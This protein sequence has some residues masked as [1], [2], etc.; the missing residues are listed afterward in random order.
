MMTKEA[1]LKGLNMYHKRL[2]N[3]F[4]DAGNVVVGKKSSTV[5]GTMWFTIDDEQYWSLYMCINGA[6]IEI[7]YGQIKSRN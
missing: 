6:R 1:V 2:K 5:E 7:A 3:E 4:A